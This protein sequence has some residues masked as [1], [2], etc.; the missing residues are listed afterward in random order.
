M[1]NLLEFNNYHLS[2]SAYLGT[3]WLSIQ[4]LKLLL[5]GVTFSFFLSVFLL[6]KEA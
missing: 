1:L 3:A 6:F 4:L 2:I 5:H